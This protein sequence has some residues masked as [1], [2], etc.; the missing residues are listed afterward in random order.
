MTRGKETMMT[1]RHRTVSLGLAALAAAALA[2][3]NTNDARAP[4]VA[5]APTEVAPPAAANA[6][7]ADAT[8]AP[9]DKAQAPTA[10][11]EAS[12]GEALG[13]FVLS[14][15]GPDKV[16]D[17]G[18]IELSAKIDAH[19]EF[20]VPTTITIELP[21]A[22]K[23][24]SGKDRES[25]ASIPAGETTR[26]FKV[27]I[28]GK[29]DKPIKVIVDARDPAGAMGAH[30]EKTFPEAKTVYVKP[31]SNVPPPPVARPP[32]GRAPSR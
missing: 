16:P 31:S 11:L 2:A 10:P 28:T 7:P 22:A 23:L 13:P 32:V 24:T 17:Q 30:A 1:L 8:N 6:A 4:Q 9:A 14:L 29:L 18:E 5:S 26:T 20:K 3:C 25:L 21:S 15:S 12:E 27:A 19:R